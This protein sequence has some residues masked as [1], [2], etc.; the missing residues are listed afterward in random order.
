MSATTRT[1]MDDAVRASLTADSPLATTVAAEVERAKQ[2][3]EPTRRSFL[4]TGGAALV[5]GF[6]VPR[7][8]RAE[9]FVPGVMTPEAAD[10]AGV[11]L[12]AFVS[13]DTAGKVT[14]VTHRAEM[15][16]GAYSVVP[17]ILAEELEVDP[18]AISIV[19][20][21]GDSQKYG[22]Q[23]TGGS[24]TVRGGITQ[25]L[26]T[27]A[28]ARDMLVRAAA[29]RWGV[30]PSACT[31]SNG[32]VMHAASGRTLGYGALVEDAAKLAPDKAVALKDR[33]AY[34][35]I[36][37][38]IP[39]ADTR[40]KVNGTAKFGLDVRVPGMLFAVVERSPRFV[41]KVKSFDASKALAVPGVKHVVKTERDIF[42]KLREGVA[43][44][45]T[46]TWAAI[47]GRR[48]LVVEW[49]D[50]GIPEVSSASIAAQN[51]AALAGQPL[52]FK[53]KGDVAAALGPAPTLD[54]TYETPYQAHACM[55]PINCTAHVTDSAAEIWGP[56]QAPDWNRG[57]LAAALKLPMDKVKVNMTF[58]GGG[59]GRKA[60]TDFPLEAALVSKAVKAPVQV[61]W[62]REDDL[63][64][65]PFRPGMMYR[66]RGALKDGKIAALDVTMAGQ[67]L[68]AQEPGDTPK[69]PNDNVTEGLP[70][71]YLETIPNYRFG[72]VPL[73]APVPVMWWRSVYS[74][75][76]GFAY[77][78]FLD[79]MARAAKMDPIAFRRQHFDTPR[80]HALAD[81]LERVSGWKG[82]KAGEGYGMSLTYCF[83]SW[84]AHVVK[85]SR[86][87]TG[88][89]AI[90]KVWTV[91]D[92]GVAV[93]PDVIR[94]QV[95]GSIVMA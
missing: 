92:C 93:N 47:K 1:P 24:S 26:K 80:L 29:A 15:G 6:V 20:A 66:L 85:V 28:T 7:L 63:G 25:L 55:E 18:L 89:I 53:S 52:G 4:K 67:N 71:T 76:N 62:T 34:K 94:Q 59:F 54:L 48:A 31:A 65:G 81:T 12:N 43:V 11:Q 90:D 36:G 17:Q 75:T 95:E 50:T 35:V 21:E 33:K 13:I 5:L 42:G 39:R 56:V 27:G 41:G 64:I 77:E 38:P 45:A 78:S 23:L 72:D 61:V 79:E 51:K 2:P 73:L 82:R 83:S 9:G 32:Q 91:M 69:K 10:A 68:M 8:A 60:F 84:A 44:V 22:S 70:E 14:L 30:D 74:S 37:K 58:L 3:S 57:H 46:S 86:A 19:V 16:Q 49:D 87:K 88:G 40:M